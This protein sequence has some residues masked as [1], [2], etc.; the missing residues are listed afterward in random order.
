M[1]IIDSSSNEKRRLWIEDGKVRYSGLTSEHT[2]MFELNT[3]QFTIVPG[4][5]TLDTS[6][7]DAFMEGNGLS[8]VKRLLLFGFTSFIKII[9]ID[10]ERTFQ[11]TLLKSRKTLDDCPLD[12]IHAVQLPISRLTD[13]LIRKIKLES[14]PIIF[15]ET[16]TTKELNQIAWRR[17]SEAMFP[18]RILLI[19]KPSS[20]IGGQEVEEIQ[21]HWETII[22]EN[23]LN[24][25]F[26]FP[27]SGEPISELLQKRIGLFP[28]KG[29]LIMGS[30]ADY[31]MYGTYQRE[32][33]P[34]KLPDIIVL[35]GKVVKAGRKWLLEG[36]KGEEMTSIVP[37]QFLPITDVNRYED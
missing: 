9:K 23:R 13:S 18:K 16:K 24:S 1:D 4:K 14:I 5:I 36:V 27:D 30:D 19:C 25:Y 17:I 28:K 2:G 12:Y 37:E 35:K 33:Q 22:M 29:S 10:H 34:L 11:R 20:A 8:Y 26:H 21:S 31:C 7:S 6:I 3:D 15:F 32:E